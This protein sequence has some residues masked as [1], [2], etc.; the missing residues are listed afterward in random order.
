VRNDHLLLSK[1]ILIEW[2]I[3]RVSSADSAARSSGK[4]AVSSLARSS[5]RL[6]SSA[7]SSEGLFLLF[8]VFLSRF[9]GISF[10][11]QIVYRYAKHLWIWLKLRKIGMDDGHHACHSLAA[12]L[13]K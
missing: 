13:T 12:T 5:A 2:R 8:T 3:R 9:S 11:W 4:C 7:G 1:P 10:G 6:L